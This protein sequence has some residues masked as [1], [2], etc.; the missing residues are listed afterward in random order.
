MRRLLPLALLST[1]ALGGCASMLFGGVNLVTPHRGVARTGGI[2]FD[3]GHALALDSY[4]PQGAHD[5][6]VV[7]FFHGGS[8]KNGQRWQYRF[9]GETLA[10]HGVVTAIPDYRTY[11]AVRFPAFIDDAARAVAFV[12]AHAG[13]WG[14]DPQRIFLMG[15]S[16]GA[17]IAALLAMDA[18]HLGEVGLAPRDLA[19]FIGLAGPYDFLPL[20]S[21]TLRAIFGADAAS[22]KNSQPV[23][24]VD[25]DEP[26]ALLLH[27][28]ADGMVWP[29]NSTAL[30]ARL[31]AQNE[32]V[33]L[34]IYPGVGHIGLLLSLA[35]P[36]RRRAATLA[37]TLA[38]IAAQPARDRVP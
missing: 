17:H 25:G 12:H 37:D 28:D 34:R 23:N 18:R 19:G 24:F 14:G 6:P 35:P 31:R 8:W 30:A 22:E 26:P 10:A 38:F 36:W 33:T 5:A 20:G 3:P 15:H 2:V 16:A 4:R 32:P 13:E 1:L 29:R 7:V 27:G 21:A 11:P 9:V